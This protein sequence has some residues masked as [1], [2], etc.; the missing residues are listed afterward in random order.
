M[1]ELK[2]LIEASIAQLTTDDGSYPKLAEDTPHQ[3]SVHVGQPVV[4]AL[5]LVGELLMIDPHKM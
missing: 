4:A 1:K 2:A 3:F 5:E